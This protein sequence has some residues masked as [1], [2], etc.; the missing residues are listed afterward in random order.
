MP[1]PP[2]HRHSE[3]IAGSFDFFMIAKK[4]YLYLWLFEVGFYKVGELKWDAA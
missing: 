3:F 1:R 2:A 4:C